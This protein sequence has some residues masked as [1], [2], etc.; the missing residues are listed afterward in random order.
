MSRP[1]RRG[2]SP[3]DN[4][5]RFDDHL[6]YIFT[7]LFGA[8]M[9]AVLLVA[10]SNLVRPHAVDRLALN[11]IVAAAALSVAGIMLFPWRRYHPHLFLVAILNGLFLIAL[12]VYFS[13]GWES[14]F[15]PFYFFVVVFCAIY[16]S[17]RLTAL[18]LPLTILVSLSP[19]LYAPDAPRLI[20]HV[21]VQVPTYLTLAFV[22][23][24]MAREVGRRERLRGEYERRLQEMRELK[25]R[26]QREA[27]T[28]RLTNLPD[29]AHFQIRLRQE[30][31]LAR[32]RDEQFTVTFLDVDDFKRVNDE[33]G[34]RI[35]DECL[36][37]VADV[38]RSSV[39]ETDAVSRQGVTSSPCCWPA[40]HCPRP[41]ITLACSGER[42]RSTPSVRLA[43]ALA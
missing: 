29:R 41:N 32:P 14:P 3:R 25:D 7:A 15:F 17:P 4:L 21:V 26:F 43:F 2:G 31:E 22:S 36:R 12:A 10:N 6:R 35:G 24:Y 39:R 37:L 30:I 1:P 18:L 27:S 28:D 40:R 23:W 20:E 42:W 9:V 13:G 34:H 11:L 33:H 8:G 5:S 16:F 19:Q 38:L